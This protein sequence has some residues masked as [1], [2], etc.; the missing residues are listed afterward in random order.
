[1]HSE[2][3][4]KSFQKAIVSLEEKGMASPSKSAVSELLSDY[5]EEV[6]DFRFGERRLRDFYNAA[7]KQEEVEIKQQ[8]V[9]DGLA[10]YLGFRGF[11]DWFVK[12]QNGADAD[13]SLVNDSTRPFTFIVL[14]LNRNKTTLL[15]LVTGFVLFLGINYINSE[16]WMKW[17]GNHFVETD[18][19]GHKVEK[20]QIVI[21][22]ENKMD[23]FKKI[24][25]TCETQFFNSKGNAQLWYGKNRKGEL[26]Y[27][28][29]LGKHPE[30][31][32]TLKPITKYMNNKYICVGGKSDL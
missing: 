6:C 25:P 32:K 28:T 24:E 5:I 19:D 9:R 20:G 11:E 30:T 14:F 16:K 31:G 27:F 8:A 12:E 2:L 17:E 26:E 1:M 29:D 21:F 7:L 13:N 3:I 4:L 18:F 15:I 22:N 10:Q 23:N